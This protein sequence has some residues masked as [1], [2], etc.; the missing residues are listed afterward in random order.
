MGNRKYYL[1]HRDEILVKQRIRNRQNYKDNRERLLNQCLNYYYSH[2][3]ERIAYQKEYKRKHVIRYGNKSK[4]KSIYGL[5][6]P[7]Y[8]ENG[9]CPQCGRKAL[10][11]FHHWDDNNPNNGQ[12][13]CTSC[14]FALHRAIKNPNLKALIGEAPPT[15]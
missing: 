1:K 10:L 6:K 11:G 4:R 14:H 13:L 5:N 3:D 9:C 15:P 2:K 12:W 7:S 8:P